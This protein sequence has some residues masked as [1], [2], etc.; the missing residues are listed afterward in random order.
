M[1]AE[2]AS[3]PFR[4]ATCNSLFPSPCHGRRTHDGRPSGC[5]ASRACSIRCGCAGVIPN[6]HTRGKQT[7]TSDITDDTIARDSRARANVQE[8]LPSRRHIG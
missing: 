6:A 4:F 5:A 7:R 1:V 8:Q 3:T 2:V